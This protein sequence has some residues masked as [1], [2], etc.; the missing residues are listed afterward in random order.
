MNKA[1]R[2]SLFFLCIVPSLGL[3]LSLPAVFSDYMVLQRDRAVP[4]WGDAVPGQS[5]IV[6]FAGQTVRAVSDNTGK[7]RVELKALETSKES[8]PLTVRAGEDILTFS[9]V[10]V[11]EVWLCSGQSNMQWNLL[12]TED[13]KA[14]AADAS[15]LRNHL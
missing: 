10:L 4:V 3:A 1:I 11:G 9:D 13:G 2:Y 8:R 12:Q 15:L 7:W 14:R 6:E 5:V